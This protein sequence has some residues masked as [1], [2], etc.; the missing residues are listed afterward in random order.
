MLHRYVNTLDGGSFSGVACNFGAATN[1]S[2]NSSYYQETTNIVGAAGAVVT[3]QVTSY[4]N[5]NG[6]P[7]SAGVQVDNAFVYL[8]NTFTVTLNGSGQGSFVS[9]V[10]G[11]PTNTGTIVRATFTITG[12]TTG[13]VGTPN[14][15]QI[16][17][18]F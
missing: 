13:Y 10:S 11:N 4:T 16:S 5:T 9:R 14:S 8:N 2:S 12:V 3:V 7:P 17:K 15:R 6:T 18:A 1:T